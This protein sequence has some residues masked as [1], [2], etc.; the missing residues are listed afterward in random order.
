MN[1]ERTHNKPQN[2]R[3][4]RARLRGVT[5]MKA[6]YLFSLLMCLISVNSFAGCEEPFGN[7]EPREGL[8][9]IKISTDQ[10]LEI[11]KYEGDESTVIYTGKFTNLDK[12]IGTEFL[13]YANPID[14]KPFNEKQSHLC[15]HVGGDCSLMKVGLCR[16]SLERFGGE[17][18]KLDARLYWRT[19]D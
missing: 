14:V 2:K 19:D 13:N 9:R 6:S 18:P 15:L 12:M 1:L 5:H 7:F 3:L 16:W 8:T 11:A 17:P 10:T 4:Q